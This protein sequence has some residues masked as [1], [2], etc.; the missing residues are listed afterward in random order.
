MLKKKIEELE[1]ETQRLQAKNF[2]LSI[3]IMKLKKGLIDPESE[4]EKMRKEQEKINQKA[5]LQAQKTKKQAPLEEPLPFLN[6][7][8]RQKIHYFMFKH[9][10]GG[11]PDSQNPAFIPKPNLSIDPSPLSYSLKI[12]QKLL[13]LA[14][15]PP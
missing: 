13:N 8:E 7:I 10:K 6:P 12:E 9:I 4:V 14:L 11:S 15:N 5:Y 2:D 1:N 3:E